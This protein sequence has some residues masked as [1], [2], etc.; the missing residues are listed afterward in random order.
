MKVD[1]SRK[2]KT[3]VKVKVN[4]YMKVKVRMIGE[5][6]GLVE[7]VISANKIERAF[8]LDKDPA[9][10]PHKEKKKR[11]KKEKKIFQKI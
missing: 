6:G 4:I 5:K 2:K 3:Y 7:W 8:H 1:I 9:S 10:Q 11:E